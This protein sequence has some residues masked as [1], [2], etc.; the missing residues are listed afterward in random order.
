M[1]YIPRKS[2]KD[3][4]GLWLSALRAQGLRPETLPLEELLAMYAKH[5]ETGL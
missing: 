2:E 1:L 4:A 3:E 5:I